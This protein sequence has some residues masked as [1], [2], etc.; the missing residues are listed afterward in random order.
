MA[1]KVISVRIPETENS[2]I[3]SVRGDLEPG[4]AIKKII[5]FLANIDHSYTKNTILKAEINW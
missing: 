5:Q 1:S 3:E 4:A 2:F